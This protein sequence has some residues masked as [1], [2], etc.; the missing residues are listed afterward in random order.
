MKMK[1][2]INMDGAAF[3]DPFELGYILRKLAD[4]VDLADSIDSLVLKD[5]NGNKVGKAKIK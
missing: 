5:V 1:I 4:R 3:A 2:K